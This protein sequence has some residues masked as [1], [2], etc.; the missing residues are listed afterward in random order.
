MLNGILEFQHTALHDL[1]Q[2]IFILAGLTL[3]GFQH[4]FGERRMRKWRDEYDKKSVALENV[5]LGMR[6]NRVEDFIDKVEAME[7]LRQWKS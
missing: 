2:S 7:K 1:L 6:I 4:Y 5:I 3:I